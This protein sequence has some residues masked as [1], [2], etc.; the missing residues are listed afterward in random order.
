MSVHFQ[1][2]VSK[3]HSGNVDATSVPQAEDGGA[4]SGVKLKKRQPSRT[5]STTSDTPQTGE[6]EKVVLRKP[7]SRSAGDVLDDTATTELKKILQRKRAAAE[8]GDESCSDG[9]FRIN[10]GF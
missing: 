9:N 10:P 3:S 8:P 4:W 2:S 6:L 5:L 7:R 1:K